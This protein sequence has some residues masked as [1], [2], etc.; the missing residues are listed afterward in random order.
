M[1]SF[2]LFPLFA[3]TNGGA[4]QN[5]P[6]SLKPPYREN[7]VYV[8]S[9]RGA[10]KQKES[11]FNIEYTAELLIRSTSAE[12]YRG[13]F[14]QKDFYFNDEPEGWEDAFRIHLDSRGAILEVE[15]EDPYISVRRLQPA[16]LIYPEK[17]IKPGDTWEYTSEKLDCLY[18]YEAKD[19]EKLD[20]KE[21]LRVVCVMKENKKDGFK[22]SGIHWVNKEGIV[23]KSDLKFKNWRYTWDGEPVEY[24]LKTKF[25][26]SVNKPK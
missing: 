15:D 13:E 11:T 12:G 9:W 3:L 18:H 17:P 25:I 21:A 6:W 1:I 22:G 26:K 7:T 14:L 19:I 8:S 23:L 20:G 16:F 2:A 5:E 10:Y 4:L 24:E